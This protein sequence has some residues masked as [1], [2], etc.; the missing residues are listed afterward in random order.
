MNFDL[1]FQKK[2]LLIIKLQITSIAAP[3]KNKLFAIEFQSKYW[4]EKGVMT[5]SK[6]VCM[7]M[8]KKFAAKHTI[9]SSLNKSVIQ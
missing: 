8:I 3:R 1:N 2:L 6:P 5:V 4:A 9:T 7:N